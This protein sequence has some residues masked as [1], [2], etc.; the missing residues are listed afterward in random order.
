MTDVVDILKTVAPTVATALGGPLAGAAVSALGKVLGID[1][2]TQDRIAKAFTD[3]QLTPDHVA[4]I[5]Q[6]ELQYQNDEKERGFRYVELQ[7]N[8]VTSAREL[9]AT[10]KNP[11]PTI[12]SYVILVGG[13]AMIAS[14]MTG[15]AK[16]DNVLAGTLIGYVVSEM[17]AV[18]QYWF[19]SSI[20]SKDKDETLAGALK[21]NS[22]TDGKLMS[23]T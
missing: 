1:A 15:T 10:T 23:K 19:G 3:G 16:V 18:L 4:Q 12:L 2:P 8:D 11:T 20:G 22:L 17:K 5:R 21:P 9:A 14:V 13:G 7:F 6:L